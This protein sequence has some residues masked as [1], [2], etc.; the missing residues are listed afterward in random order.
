MHTCR[1]YSK[2][3]ILVPY[4]KKNVNNWHQFDLFSRLIICK[5]NFQTWSLHTDS[6]MEELYTLVKLLSSRRIMNVRLENIQ[7]VVFIFVKNVLCISL[8]K[9]L[10]NTIILLSTLS[11]RTPTSIRQSV[12]D[13]TP[14]TNCY[15]MHVNEHCPSNKKLH[16]TL[17]LS[18]YPFTGN[19]FTSTPTQL[20]SLSTSAGAK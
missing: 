7:C 6:W 8:K 2:T 20:A 3:N 17:A 14:T 1:E 18:H 10:H 16:A 11:L 12:F 5:S 9:T 15:V 4:H 13:T 19:L